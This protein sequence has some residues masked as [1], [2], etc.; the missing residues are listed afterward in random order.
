M[1]EGHLQGRRSWLAVQTALRVEAA[2]MPGEC[3]TKGLH[4][5][6]KQVVLLRVGIDAGCGSI[7][8]PLFQDGSFDFVC[9]P[10]N[11]GVSVH[12]GMAMEAI[13][14]KS[15]ATVMRPI[16]HPEQLQSAVQHAAGFALLLG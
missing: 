9:I 16:R 15:G 4:G 10:D 1:A 13:G 8:G 14:R 2:E 7:Q 11:K 6:S 12:A 5:M 3:A